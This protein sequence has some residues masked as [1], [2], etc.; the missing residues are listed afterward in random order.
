VPDFIFDGWPEVGIDDYE[1]ACATVAAAA[2]DEPETPRLGWI[3]NCDTHPSRRL[4]TNIGEEHPDLFDFHHV[5]WVQK[6]SQTRLSSAANNHLSL[7]EQVRR[8]SLL[9]DVEGRGYSARLK[10]LLHSG[11]P[12]LIQER[13]WREWFWGELRPMEH[14]I[15]VRRDLSDLVERVRWAREHPDAAARIGAAG[16]AFARTR[17]RRADAVREWAR[18]LHVLARQ[19]AM[20]YAPRAQRR[21]LDRVVAQAS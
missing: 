5:T 19:P 13:P 21:I 6:P 17:L 11:R 20:P 3:G 14:F 15:P 9:L 4:L 2:A 16:Q 7:A 18:T 10:L 8:W 1:E 12:V